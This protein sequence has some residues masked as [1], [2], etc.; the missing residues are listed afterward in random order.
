MTWLSRDDRGQRR[1]D[2]PT[3][4]VDRTAVTGVG[5]LPTPKLAET[6]TL[7]VLRLVGNDSSRYYQRC[8]TVG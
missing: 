3:N 8:E 6:V 4:S 1:N 7:V 2:Y 5:I